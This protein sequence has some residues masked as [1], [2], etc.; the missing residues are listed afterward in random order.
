MNVTGPQFLLLYVALAA[1]ANLW[2]RWHYGTREREARPATLSLTNDPYQIALLRGGPAEAIRVAVITLLNR[3]L[4]TE[5]NGRLHAARTDAAGFVRH[6]LDRAL[7]ETFRDPA[8]VEQALKSRG[9]LAACKT[10]ERELEKKQLLASGKTRAARFAPLVI[11]L[12][13][14]LGIAAWRIVYALAKGRT[15]VGFLVVLAIVCTVA[16][17]IAYRK[18]L[19]A[20]GVD[21]LRGLERLYTGAKQRIATSLVDRDSFDASL[22][23]AVFGLGALSTADFPY[24]A[25]VFPPPKP[26]QSAG[27]SCGSTCGSSCGGGGCGGGCGGCGG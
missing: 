27:S 5:E 15:N 22:I 9:A 14:T 21:T 24:L 16:L 19:T 12:G 1:A 18:R 4:L 13:F 20:L 11:A 7:L 8:P 25:R 23:A 6:P 2:L 26:S 3:G 10:Y 17:V